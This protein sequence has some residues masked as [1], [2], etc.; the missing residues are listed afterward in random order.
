[1][2]Y[3]IESYD[4]QSGRIRVAY[5]ST[6]E[7]VSIYSYDLPSGRGLPLSEQELDEAIRA[8]A[9]MWRLTASRSDETSGSSLATLELGAHVHPIGEPPTLEDC[10][11][12]KIAQIR[13]FRNAVLYGDVPHKLGNYHANLAHAGWLTAIATLGL[14]RSKLPSPSQWPNRDHRLV[15]IGLEDALDLLQAMAQ[16]AASVFKTAEQKEQA[17]ATAQT[18]QAVAD[19]TWIEP[20]VE[21][22]VQQGNLFVTSGPSHQTYETEIAVD[23]V[24][25]Q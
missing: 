25:V 22:G 10:K 19:V 23:R 16:H 5:S 6:E 17:I 13:R 11:A 24:V 2:N 8:R 20:G 14:A 18:A 7:I 3:K 12:A 9:P 4:P 1:M 15:D 21:G